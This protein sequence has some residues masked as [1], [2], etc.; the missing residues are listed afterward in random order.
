M[1][2]FPKQIVRRYSEAAKGPTPLE[3]QLQTPDLELQ[4][5]LD[6]QW[7]IHIDSVNALEKEFQA[8]YEKYHQQQ[9]EQQKRMASEVQRLEGEKKAWLREKQEY[10][11]QTSKDYRKNKF[12]ISIDT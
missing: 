12:S 5:S 8:R 6:A 1:S 3:T 4:Q 10:Q 2:D 11:Y 7:Q 9:C